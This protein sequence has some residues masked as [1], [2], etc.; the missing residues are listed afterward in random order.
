LPRAATCTFS[1]D[2]VTLDANGKQSISLTIDSGSPLTAGSIAKNES[3]LPS[4]ISMC[5]LPGGFILVFSLIRLRRDSRV[6]PGLLL[7]LLAMGSM[8]LS[9]CGLDVH[10]TPAGTYTFNVTAIGSKT[11]VTQSAVMTLTVTK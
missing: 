2:Q 3:R 6:L 11:S 10:G 9:G 1:S 8:A 7:L 5:L 4:G